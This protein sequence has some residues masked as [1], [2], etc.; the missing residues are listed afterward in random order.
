MDAYEEYI[1]SEFYNIIAYQEWDDEK[2][3]ARMYW[4]SISYVWN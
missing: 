1:D 4:F 3:V 2:W